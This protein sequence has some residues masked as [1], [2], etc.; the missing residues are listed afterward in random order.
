MYVYVCVCVV[1]KVVSSTYEAQLATHREMDAFFFA[2]FKWVGVRGRLARSR[3][4]KVMHPSLGRF[5][6][7]ALREIVS[8]YFSSALI[9]RPR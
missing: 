7:L 8:S 2:F 4:L 6:T 1:V 9:F 5:N 3:E